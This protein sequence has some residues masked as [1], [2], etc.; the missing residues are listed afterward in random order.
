[1]TGEELEGHGHNP[2]Y[3]K[4]SKLITNRINKLCVNIKDVYPRCEINEI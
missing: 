3:I 2:L 4:L 1:M